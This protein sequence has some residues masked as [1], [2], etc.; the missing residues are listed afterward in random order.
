MLSYQITYPMLLP[1]LKEVFVDIA[2]QEFPVAGREQTDSRISLLTGVHRKDV[3][4]LRDEQHADDEPPKTV[5]L[6]A[7]VVARWIGAPEFLDSLGKPKA[8]PRFH[9]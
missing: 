1:I 7:E 8:L 3:R 9:Q 4:R 6:A 2:E 5:S